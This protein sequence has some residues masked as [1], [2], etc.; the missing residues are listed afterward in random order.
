MKRISLI[1]YLLVI[2]LTISIFSLESCKNGVSSNE[3]DTTEN[4][5]STEDNIEETV[6]EKINWDGNWSYFWSPGENEGG[7]SVFIAYDITISGEECKFDANGYQTYLEFK[8]RGE[9]KGDKYIIYFEEDLSD[10]WTELEKGDVVFTLKK[11]G[12]N[13]IPIDDEHMEGEDG[14]KIFEILEDEN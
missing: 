5:I 14:E 4:E 12:N 11:E 2:L 3:T 6:V 7:V 9:A 13:L 8:C 1:S 10:S